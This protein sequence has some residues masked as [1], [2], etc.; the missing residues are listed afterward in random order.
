MFRDSLTWFDIYGDAPDVVQHWQALLAESIAAGETPAEE[1][2]AEPP[3][4]KRRR[5][6]RRRGLR[7]AT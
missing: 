2:G 6:R 4:F 1:A 7:P 3:P 5:R